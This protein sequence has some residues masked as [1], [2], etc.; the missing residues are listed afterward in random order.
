M[1]SDHRKQLFEETFSSKT[2]IETGQ[3]LSTATL[4]KR[5]YKLRVKIITGHE[6]LMNH[7]KQDGIPCRG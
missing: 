4:A 5:L 3:C 1:D 6:K 7:L 2:E